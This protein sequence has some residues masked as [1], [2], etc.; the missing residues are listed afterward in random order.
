MERMYTAASFLGRAAVVV[1]IV[2]E[3]LQRY[4]ERGAAVRICG[5]GRNS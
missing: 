5:L 1:M 4:T 2:R 3:R